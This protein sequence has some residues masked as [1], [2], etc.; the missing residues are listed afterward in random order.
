MRKYELCLVISSDLTSEN[1]QKLITK[2]KKI[3]TEL[4]G[5]ILKVKEWGRKEFS[6]PVKKKTSGNYFLWEIELSEKAIGNFTKKIKLEEEVLRY[7]L[8]KPFDKLRVKEKHG[9]KIAK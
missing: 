9:A 1:S 8:I 5:Q 3:I 6:Y 4:E 2:I 7:L